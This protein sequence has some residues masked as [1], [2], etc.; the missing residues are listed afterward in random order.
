L[1][2]R[3]VLRAHSG[4]VESLAFAPDGLTLFS[5]GSDGRIRRWDVA[6]GRPLAPLGNPEVN[7]PVS[8][9]AISHD[10]RTLAVPPIGLWALESGRLLELESF[11]TPS[12]TVPVAFSPVA[13]IV[14]MVHSDTIRLWD[15]AT[16]KLLR[17]LRT[18]PEHGVNSLAFAPDGRILASAGEDLR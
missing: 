11:E 16:G 5:G 2:E 1:A 4:G 13:A 18:P 15:A 14:A 6:K 12:L 10:G 8:G 3:D 7:N 17:S 9:L